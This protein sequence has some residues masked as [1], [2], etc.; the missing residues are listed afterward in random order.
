MENFVSL[1]VGPS[2]SNGNIE[3]HGKSHEARR[4]TGRPGGIRGLRKL[5]THFAAFNT[6]SM[7]QPLEFQLL[8]GLPSKQRKAF[9]IPAQMVSRSNL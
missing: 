1:C 3:F 5:T 8:K 2:E 9:R 6:W 4:L 7:C